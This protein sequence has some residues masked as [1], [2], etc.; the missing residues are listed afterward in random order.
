VIL[1]GWDSASSL[2]QCFDTWSGDKN[3]IEK[4]VKRFS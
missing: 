4:P 2:L 1:P 3:G